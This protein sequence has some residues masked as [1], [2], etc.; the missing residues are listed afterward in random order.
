[1]QRPLVAV[2]QEVGNDELRKRH[3]L[4]TQAEDKVM[5]IHGVFTNVDEAMRRAQQEYEAS[6]RLQEEY[7]ELKAFRA[8]CAQNLQQAERELDAINKAT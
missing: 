2:Q 4:K 8:E 6:R 7:E 3:T 5:A 1:M